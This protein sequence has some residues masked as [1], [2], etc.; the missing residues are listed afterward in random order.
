MQEK[1]VKRKYNGTSGMIGIVARNE[2]D[3]AIGA[4]TMYRSRVEAV[5]FL[6]PLLEDE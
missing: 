2:A 4:F 1:W 3:A 6:I 5:D